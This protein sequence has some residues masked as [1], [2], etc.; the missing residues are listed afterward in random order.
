[1]E[2]DTSGGLNRSMGYSWQ[3]STGRVDRAD[4]VAVEDVVDQA[5]TSGGAAV[6]RCRPQRARAAG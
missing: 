3:G 1:M 5:A 2:S 4:K 6:T